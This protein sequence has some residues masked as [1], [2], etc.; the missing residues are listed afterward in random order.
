MISYGR[1]QINQ[2]D[3][4]AVLETLK[5]DF[6]TQ[7]PMVPRF[8]SSVAGYCGATHAVAVSNATAALH[9]ACMALDVGPG[10][11]VWTSPI[12]FVASANCALY[13]DAM[14]D[15]VDINNET[16]NMDIECLKE[17]LEEA[18]SEN[19]LPKVVIPVHLS[20]QSCE[21]AKIHDLAREYGF[22]VIEDASHAIGGK[23]L[24]TPIGDCRY[25]DISVFSFHPVKI[26]T[27]GEGGMAL[28][29]SPELA[30]RMRQLRSHGTVRGSDKLQQRRP[31]EIWNYQQISLGFNY[32]LTDIQ[33]ALGV[34]QMARLD[35]FVAERHEVAQF[36]NHE[37]DGLTIDI[38][39]QH[40]DCHSSFHLYP[41]RIR[42]EESRMTQRQAYDALRAAGI[43]VNLHYIPIYRQP[44]FEEMG[45][46]AGYCPEAECYFRETL[47]IPIHH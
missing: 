12:S 1:Q 45:F 24:G 37:L 43:G 20:G 34:S 42:L 23:Y 38:P 16:Y 33:A 26:I 31:D 7:G 13:C 46:V 35:E 21:M 25:S 4:D 6:L 10:D 3:I 29:N 2:A 17:K 18:K 8:E 36:Y 14:V 30:E 28:C 32:R 19:K 41:I 15:F 11:Y 22:K 27:T 44:Y 47:S 5:S 9:I 39:R 40:V